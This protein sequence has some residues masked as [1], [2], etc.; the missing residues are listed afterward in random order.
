MRIALVLVL[1]ACT[2]TPD[3]ADV[4][5]FVVPDFLHVDFDFGPLP[6]TAPPQVGGGAELRRYCT[7]V[8][9][10][11]TT[12]VYR[13]ANT[14]LPV[15]RAAGHRIPELSRLLRVFAAP[16]IKAVA[17]RVGNV[18]NGSPIG[19]TLPALPALGAQAEIQSVYGRR[20]LPLPKLYAGYRSLALAR[21]RVITAVR[22]PAPPAAALL[23]TVKVCQRKDLDSSFVGAAPVLRR[24]TEDRAEGRRI[25]AGNLY[26][27]FTLEHSA[28][29]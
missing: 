19:D 29:S 28:R 25:L 18:A 22:I 9:Q 5:A 17:T 10:C 7:S 21:S 15:E 24:D 20:M 1:A 23:S 8:E 27:R 3:A 12:E 26:Q 6:T 11:V 13:P 16:Q 14:S 2:A 4:A